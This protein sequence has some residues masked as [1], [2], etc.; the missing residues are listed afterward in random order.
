MNLPP[1][2]QEFQR[3]VPEQ[4]EYI[5]P[6]LDLD[7]AAYQAYREKQTGQLQR[8]RTASA[9]YLMAYQ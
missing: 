9:A 5:L 1:V 8:W 3:A 2:I 6:W 4:K 7:I